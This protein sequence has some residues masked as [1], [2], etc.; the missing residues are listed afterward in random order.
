MQF[1]SM[2]KAEH[3]SNSLTEAIL[4][5]KRKLEAAIESESVLATALYRYENLLFFYIE[6]VENDESMYA[7]WSDQRSVREGIGQWLS[8][9][10]VFLCESFRCSCEEGYLQTLSCRWNF[11]VPVFY[12]SQSTSLATWKRSSIPLEQRGRIA[13]LKD[14]KIVDYIYHHK[15]ITDEGHLIGD[16]YQFISMHENILFSYFEEPKN[17]TNIVNDLTLESKAIVHW[18]KMIPEEHFTPI[19]KEVISNFTFIPALFTLCHKRI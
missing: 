6:L 15:A 8:D 7:L 2:L 10:D 16:K 1:R 13:V 14:E 5:C 18:L 9:L 11:M 19:Q 3:D 4:H 12:H 17:L